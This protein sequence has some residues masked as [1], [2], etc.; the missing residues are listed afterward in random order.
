MFDNVWLH[1]CK[2]DAYFA[3]QESENTNVGA[4][5]E[6]RE[7]KVVKVKRMKDKDG[8][9]AGKVKVKLLKEKKKLKRKKLGLGLSGTGEAGGGVDGVDAGGT[10]VDVMT[11]EGREGEESPSKNVKLE[12]GL[13]I[14]TGEPFLT[15]KPLKKK[16]KRKD[17]VQLKVNKDGF[18]MRPCEFMCVFVCVCVCFEMRPCEFVCVCLCVMIYFTD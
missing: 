11:A 17:K 1:V 8:L 2:Y 9:K 18:Q 14:D 13:V 4:M 12:P 6:P 15:P 7:K 10:T 3:P 5:K 16:M